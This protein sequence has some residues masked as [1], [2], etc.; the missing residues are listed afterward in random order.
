MPR[1]ARYVDSVPRTRAIALLT[2]LLALVVVAAGC[3]SSDSTAEPSTTVESTTA[4]PEDSTAST[5]GKVS[6]NDAS[7]DELTAAFEAA[8]IAN[9]DR[10]AF[11]VDEY[12]PYPDDPTFAKLRDELSKYNPSPETLEAIIATLEP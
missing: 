6:A 2:T 9:A 1:I 3:G 12:R 8:G 10:W 11:E 7:I 5:A 4:S